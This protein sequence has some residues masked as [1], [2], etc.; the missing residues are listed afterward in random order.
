MALT[1]YYHNMTEHTHTGASIDT[2][3][4]HAAHATTILAGTK[5]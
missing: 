4:P 2:R 1:L 5:P 3:P